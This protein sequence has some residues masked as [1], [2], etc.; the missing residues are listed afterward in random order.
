MSFGRVIA[1]LISAGLILLGLIFLVAATDPR[2]AS[3]LGRA[4]I[5]G[6]FA[7]G[8]VFLLV[9]ILRHRAAATGV[10]APGPV[11]QQKI[12]LSGDVQL[13]NLACARCGGAITQEN[14]RVQAGAAF[15][16]CPFCGSDYQLEEKPKW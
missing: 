5:G 7:A 10:G 14:I 12:E 13:Q 11:I 16:K 9:F 4:L 8:G 15:V 3:P 6:L 1:I 2:A